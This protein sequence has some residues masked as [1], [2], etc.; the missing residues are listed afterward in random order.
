MENSSILIVSMYFT[1]FGWSNDQKTI[2]S[3]DAY[4]MKAFLVSCGHFLSR[5]CNF[6]TTYSKFFKSKA[7]NTSA[8]PPFPINE[9]TLYLLF[10]IGHYSRLFS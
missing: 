8:N 6:T 1:M 7:L 4:L 2:F 5:Y 9:R 10:N 3:L